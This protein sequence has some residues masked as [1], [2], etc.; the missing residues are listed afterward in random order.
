MMPKM[1]NSRLVRVLSLMERQIWAYL[2]GVIVVGLVLAF[3]FNLVMGFVFKDVLNAALV[4]DFSLLLRGAILALATFVLGMP[5]VCFARYAIS[6]A[7]CQTLTS[8]RVGLFSKITR[9]PMAQ[10]EAHHSGDL[11]SRATNDVQTLW[12]MFLGTM[13]SFAHAIGQGSI[14]LGAIFV[15][16]WRLG[17]VALG[18]GLASFAASTRFAGILRKRSENLQASVAT[19]TER[20]SDLLAGIAVTRMFRLEAKIH[21]HYAAASGDAA[22]RTI[23]HARSQAAF[24]AIQGLLDWAQR[25]GTLAIGLILFARGHLLI[26]SVWAI[27]HLQGNASFLFNYIGQFLTGIQRGLA[28]GQRVLDVLGLP[29]EEIRSAGA[30]PEPSIPSEASLSL[31]DVS[32]AYTDSEEVLRGVSLRVQKGSIAALVGPSGGGKSTLLKL[33]LGFYAPRDGEL[34]IEGISV[35]ERSLHVLRERTAYVPQNA[36]LFSGTIEANIGYGREGATHDEIMAAATAAHAH[37]FILQQPDGYQTQVGEQGTKLS[38]GQRQ[39]IAI[40][41]ALLKDAP[42]LLLD[43]ATSA[44]DSESESQVQAALDVLMK[45][46]TTVAIAHR[47]STIEHADQIFVLDAGRIVEQGDHQ[48][49]LAE[50]GLYRQLYELQFAV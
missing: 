32:F 29:E 41:R 40:A 13:T 6:R 23:A 7:T 14:G 12:Q 25:F 26:G 1:K 38:G 47:L 30:P 35:T 18:I 4:G 31:H 2:L 22:Q 16:E 24:E 44:L 46:R 19:M 37:D 34:Q 21:G 17:F 45:G 3:C 9:L 39:R 8:V 11:I 48:E 27:V 5:A 33:L 49:L 10:L 28:G 20:L 43:E 50:G 36:Y 42:I 15:L